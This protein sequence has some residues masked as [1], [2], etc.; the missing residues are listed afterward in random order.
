MKIAA[1]V[2]C[3]IYYVICPLRTYSF[4]SIYFCVLLFLAFFLYFVL[5]H[6]LLPLFWGEP[7][8]IPLNVVI[9]K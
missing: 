5:M 8:A 4:I 6:W 9:N 3:F 1:E 7:T 2:F